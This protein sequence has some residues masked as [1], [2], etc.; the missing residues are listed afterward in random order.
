MRREDEVEALVE[1]WLKD[2]ARPMPP[3]VLEAVRDVVP[4]T[5]QRGRSWPF[6]SERWGRWYPRVGVAA[7]AILVL[8]AGPV[9]VDRLRTLLPGPAGAGPGILE[10]SPSPS[11]SPF[12]AA[13]PSPASSPTTNASAIS[14]PFTGA[15]S[16]LDLDGSPMTLTFAG[17]GPTRT[18]VVEDLRATG[19]AGLHWTADGIGTIAGL[20][21]HVV[22]SSGCS[23]QPTAI[24]Y[25]TTWTYDPAQGTLRALADAT[26]GETLVWTLGPAKPDAFSGTWTA[27]G[28]DGTTMTLSLSGS[29]MTRDVAYVDQRAPECRPAADFSAAGIGT[30]G[31]VLGDGRFIKVS[32]HGSCA[33]GVSPRDYVEKY[34]YDYVTGTL[35]GPLAPL[36]IGGN[37]LPQTVAWRRG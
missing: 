15:W 20:S 11:S 30:I 5:S 12:A 19:C 36:E 14:D 25:D 9:A 17:E 2:E 7:A 32:F 23:G 31:S 29:G 16:T 28:I 33:G 18:V 24:G 3:R 10:P 35:L 26:G 21:I 6:A 27:T 37:P 22:G 34:K 1:Q 8:V 4:R 13:S